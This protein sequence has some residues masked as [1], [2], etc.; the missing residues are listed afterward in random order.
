MNTPKNFIY[1]LKN[2][3]ITKDTLGF[4]IYSINKRA[5]NYRDKEREYRDYYK[6]NFY[7]YD[8][9]GN[10]DRN[11]EKKLDMYKK[12]QYLL[13][14]L[15]PIKIHKSEIN[16][17]YLYFLYYELEDYKFHSPIEKDEFVDDEYLEK[18]YNLK[19]KE[20]ESLFNSG[21]DI[22]EILSLDFCNKV[23]EAFKENRL[24]II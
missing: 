8:K 16:N 10:E 12:K 4:V 14:F 3:F 18:R 9:F 23:I 21:K 20:I 7:A 17:R 22:K 13:N 15:I 11:E 5:K 19:V 1:N 24:K 2:G 6:R